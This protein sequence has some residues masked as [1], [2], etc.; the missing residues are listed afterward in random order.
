M[1]VGSGSWQKQEAVAVG[2]GGSS[3]DSPFTFSL[4]SSFLS[5]SPCL[6]GLSEDQEVFGC[7]SRQNDTDTGS[8]V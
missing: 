1:E 8:L 6:S 7:L 5:L 2:S 3:H 4:I